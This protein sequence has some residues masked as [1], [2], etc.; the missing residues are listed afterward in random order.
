[1]MSLRFVVFAYLF[2]IVATPVLAKPSHA[3]LEPLVQILLEP[4][5]SFDLDLQWR[6]E[7]GTETCSLRMLRENPE[8]FSLRLTADSREFHLVRTFESCTLRVPSGNLVF[9]GKGPLDTNQPAFTLSNVVQRI[10]KLGPELEG[11]GFWMRSGNLGALLNTLHKMVDLKISDSDDG[12]FAIEVP[13]SGSLTWQLTVGEEVGRSVETIPTAP[14]EQIIEV[15]RSELERTLLRGAVR[16][17]G[18]QYEQ[19]KP[20]VLEDGKTE[21]DHGILEIRDGQRIVT[22]WGTPREIGKQHGAF[23]RS[24]I[25]DVV[26]STLYVVGLF[27]SLEKGRWFPDALRENL[28][29]TRPFIPERYFEEIRGIGEG[30]NLEES[31]ILLTTCFPELFHCSGFAVSGKAT[32]EGTLYHGRVLD[33]MTGIGLQ[34]NA[35]LFVI[36]PEGRIPFAN[37]GY[38]GL[39]GSVTGMN[40]QKVALGEMGGGGEGAWD[41]VPMTILMRMA[42]ENA[43]TLQEAVDI[44][45][46]APRTCE[47]FYVFSDGKDRSSIG[48]AAWPEKI[49]FIAPGAAHELLPKPQPDCV[50][51]SAGDRYVTLAN[52]VQH[53]FGRIDLPEAIALMDAPVSMGRDNLH[54]VLFVPEKL[55]LHVA[56]ARGKKPAY[57]NPYFQYSL[58]ALLEAVPDSEK[59]D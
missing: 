2:W 50:I 32:S 57:Q 51:L 56:N 22:L 14:N 36:A 23:L 34:E 33:Y 17:V 58:E 25:R 13:G 39:V 31:E 8:T 3:C 15:P 35:A 28:R 59:T 16:L 20:P 46:N 26:D 37:V 38:A 43:N 52:R 6:P 10:F 40:A 49:D 55:H 1:M 42:L 24:E 12:Q 29:R 48:V 53:R 44:F 45:Q 7:E 18:I 4:E 5:H 19:W 54:N 27:Y 47:Y 30:A 11:M 21:G 9:H 41:G